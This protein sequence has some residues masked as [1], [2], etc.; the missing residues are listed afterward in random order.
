MMPPQIAEVG[1]IILNF[2]S[3]I[4]A[5]MIVFVPS[6]AFL[7]SVVAAWTKSGLWQK[8][9]AKKKVCSQRDREAVGS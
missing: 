8:M 9:A 4:P 1:Q 3:M 7:N 5:G 2:A 6:Y